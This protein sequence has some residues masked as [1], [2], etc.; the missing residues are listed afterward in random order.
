[1]SPQ[2]CAPEQLAVSHRILCM[3]HRISFHYVHPGVT[4]RTHLATLNKELL[5]F[6]AAPTGK[7]PRTFRYDTV[8]A[9]L[10]P[11]DFLSNWMYDQVV[12]FTRVLTEEC[13]EVEVRQALAMLLHRLPGSRAAFPMGIH[14]PPAGKQLWVRPLAVLEW[15]R[16][17]CV[18]HAGEA[19]GVIA[20]AAAALQARQAELEGLDK[21]GMHAAVSW[22]FLSSDFFQH[23]QMRSVTPQAGGGCGL[24][25]YQRN[26][27]VYGGATP[28]LIAA[29]PGAGKTRTIGARALYLQAVLV[30][31]KAMQTSMLAEDI[32]AVTFTRR[33]KDDL[34]KRLGAEGGSV[35]SRGPAPVIATMDGFMLGLI[36]DIRKLACKLR[37]GSGVAPFTTF[38]ALANADEFSITQNVPVSQ[39]APGGAERATLQNLLVGFLTNPL[40]AVQDAKLLNEAAVEL[41]RALVVEYRLDRRMLRDPPSPELSAAIGRR[42]EATLRDK[43]NDTRRHLPGLFAGADGVPAQLIHP[44]LTA[45]S[46]HMEERDVY[47]F[48]VDKEPLA[49]ALLSGAGART[50][51]ACDPPDWTQV[52]AVQAAVQEYKRVHSRTHYIVDEVQDTNPAQL[53]VFALLCERSRLTVVGDSD[54]AIYGFRGADYAQLEQAFHDMRPA[55]QVQSPTLTL[56]YNYRSTAHIVAVTSA[57][58]APN[59]P[60]G[61]QK[62]LEASRNQERDLPVYVLQG[63]GREG[64]AQHRTM[65]TQIRKWAVGGG[66]SLHKI[67]VLFHSK[68]QIA[69]FTKF[70]DAEKFERYRTLAI[71]P[72]SDTADDESAQPRADGNLVISTVHGAKG[73]EWEIVFVCAFD[74]AHYT[75]TELGGNLEELRRVLYVACSRPRS[76][77]YI[78]YEQHNPLIAPVLAQRAHIELVELEGRRDSGAGALLRLTNLVADA[79]QLTGGETGRLARH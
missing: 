8:N 41:L 3:L 15:M 48:D 17:L 1:M 32:V 18:F 20:H 58:I 66:V 55:D 13:G 10:F 43:K 6:G 46:A 79:E 21:H 29:G 50:M 63:G 68:H 36:S 12:K 73:L 56:R 4:D 78:L 2:L 38:L 19:R 57:V 44:A 9:F 62:E 59:Y 39:L 45:L 54:Q 22:A 70:L 26:A 30:G 64:G 49:L 76:L 71:N 67:A 61:G 25:A 11:N 60:D 51:L 72:R 35:E 69:S 37:P 77:L 65:L 23:L 27:A 7:E 14:T 28:L 24:D 74:S 52:E 5:Q 75:A 47:S 33:A 40:A 16:E 31:S 53:C 42:F 34:L